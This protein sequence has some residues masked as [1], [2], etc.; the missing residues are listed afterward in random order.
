MVGNIGRDLLS[1]VRKTWSTRLLIT[2]GR[3]SCRAAAGCL[4]PP[5]ELLKQTFLAAILAQRQDRLQVGPT[6]CR[7]VRLPGAAGPAD[8]E[9]DAIGSQAEA[10]AEA[11]RL[12]RVRHLPGCRPHPES[13]LESLLL[14]DEPQGHSTAA[15]RGRPAQGLPPAATIATWNRCR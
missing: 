14:I 12:A 2:T 5:D 10:I 1:W 15:D 4:H 7:A 6:C 8:G 3:S 9:I 13:P 11:A